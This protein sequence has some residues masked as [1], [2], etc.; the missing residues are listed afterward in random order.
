MCGITGMI[1]AR[2]KRPLDRGLLKQMNDAL[3]HRGPDGHGEHFAPGVALG[4]R[5]L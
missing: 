5:R 2:G 1:D 3:S 4:H